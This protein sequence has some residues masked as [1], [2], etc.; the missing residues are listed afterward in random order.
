MTTTDTVTQAG[1]VN[2]FLIATPQLQDSYFAHSLVYVWRHTDE[3]ALGIVVNLPLKMQLAEIFSQLDMEDQRPSPAPQTVLSGGPVETDKGF[4]VH[5]APNQWLSTIEVSD[6]IRITT[7]RD[8]LS[9]ISQARGP[10]NY[11]VA[12]GCAGWDSGQLEQEIAAN[13]WLTCPARKDILFSTDFA[14]KPELAVATLGFD[15]AQ[16]APTASSC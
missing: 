2:H 8:I 11:L 14:H 9:D 1:L 4:I 16:L 3:G 10:E 6:D 12:L 15:M 5:D 13:A 7:S